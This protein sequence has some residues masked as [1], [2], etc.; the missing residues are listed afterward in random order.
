M[1]SE[2]R[3]GQAKYEM[4]APYWQGWADQ[5][6]ARAATYRPGVSGVTDMTLHMTI[7]NNGSA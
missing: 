2:M 7:N 6:C 3:Y 5:L 4:K 1:D